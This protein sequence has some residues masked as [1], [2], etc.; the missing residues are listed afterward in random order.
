MKFCD[1][2]GQVSIAELCDPL[3]TFTNWEGLVL[4]GDSLQLEPTITSRAFNEFI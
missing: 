3:T 1:E 4:V 2:A